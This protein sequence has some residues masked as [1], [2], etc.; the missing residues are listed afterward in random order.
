MEQYIRTPLAIR[1][2]GIYGMDSFCNVRKCYNFCTF[3]RVMH[4]VINELGVIVEI[5]SND[6]LFKCANYLSHPI[7][8]KLCLEDCSC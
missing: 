4:N 1:I 2:R 3:V 8:P 7:L 5:S 6:K